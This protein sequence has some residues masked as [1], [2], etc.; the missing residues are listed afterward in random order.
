MD[1]MFFILILP[2]FIYWCINEK[3]GLQ[4]CVTALISIWA[5]LVYT[6][7]SEYLPFNF[8]IRLFIVAVIFC[9][10]L[11]LHKKI[12]KLISKGGFR[13]FMITAAAFS[14]IMILYR[15]DFRFVIPAGLFLGLGIGYCLNKRYVGFKSS[16][17]LQR[18]GPAKYLT[19]LARF[20]LGMAVL[21]LIV[22]R[23]EVIIEQIS[24][25]QNVFLYCFLCYALIG[26][27]VSIASPW[28][29]IKLRLAG[30]EEKQ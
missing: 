22:L 8:D 26:F 28:I 20:L 24:K 25:S 4:L 23:V 17:V 16:N 21:A 12:E 3:I 19:L 10:Y 27:W 11:F 18:T 29:F 9:G 15:P 6:H 7:L 30:I 2:F 13:A 14:F 1:L 5:I